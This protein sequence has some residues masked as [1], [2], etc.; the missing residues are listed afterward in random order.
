MRPIRAITSVA[1][2]RF[3]VDLPP[4]EAGGPY[5]LTIE[6]AGERLEIRDV[7][8][9]DVWLCS[10]QSNMEW[11]VAHSMNAAAE[12]ANA[13]DPK[14]RH[15]KVPRSWAE[16]PEPELAGGSWAAA[17]PNPHGYPRPRRPASR[18]RPVSRPPT[19][20]AAPWPGSRTVPWPGWRATAIVERATCRPT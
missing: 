13:R 14:I 3:R 11:V 17:R 18:S 12:V 10:G 7:L 9:G 8:I 2:I 16:Q 1:L 20:L 15:F 4:R 5:T 6:A 19:C